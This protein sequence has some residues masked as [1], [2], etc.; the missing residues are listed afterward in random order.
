VDLYDVSTARLVA[1]WE[2]AGSVPPGRVRAA[3]N[4][5]WLRRRWLHTPT[6]PK[7]VDRLLTQA[8]A[9]EVRVLY[10]FVGPMKPGGRFGWRDG[11][12]LVEYEPEV[13]RSFFAAVRSAAHSTARSGPYFAA[14][15][16]PLILPWTGGVFGRDAFPDDPVWR[17]DFVAQAVALVALGADGVHVNIEPMPEESRGYLDLLRELK[18]AL[19]G[20]VVSVAAY[21]PPTPLH[22]Y[23]DVHWSPA[24]LTEVCGIADDISVMTYDTALATPEAYAGLITEW[25]EVLAEALHGCRWRVG[26]PTYEE[27]KPWHRPDAEI[28]SAALDGVAA[29]K[30]GDEGRTPPVGLAVYASWTTDAGEWAEFDLRRGA[31][32]QDLG[33]ID[34]P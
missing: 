24:F 4:G 8:A 25:T 15:R 6:T 29:A 9:H 13:A 27:D 16:P 26:I 10:P 3:D 23:P 14:A 30:P 18:A 31:V 1:T 7:D 21:P 2:R 32:P 11:E 33:V 22:P 34:P 20:R 17:A 5:L 28:L 12:A 19:P